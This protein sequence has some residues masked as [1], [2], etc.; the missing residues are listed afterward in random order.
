MS[1]D[2]SKTKNFMEKGG[3]KTVFRGVVEFGDNS[4]FAGKGLPMA[5]IANS[6]ATSVADLKTAYNTLLRELKDAGLMAGD[7]L[8]GVTVDENTSNAQPTA[9]TKAN[10]GHA[11]LSIA[12]GLITIAL[13]CKVSDLADANHGAGW[14]TH[15]WLGFEVDTGLASIVG[16]VFT[17]GRGGKAVLGDADVAEATALGL[18]AGSFILYIKAEDPGYLN[19]TKWFALS[20]Q[21]LEKTVFKMKITETAA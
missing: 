18:S 8:T 5:N 19:G 4:S 14:G 2:T 10:S 17:D 9:Q 3:D 1:S 6:T 7:A 15:K 13:D 16:L 12:D 11:T 20:G 21:G